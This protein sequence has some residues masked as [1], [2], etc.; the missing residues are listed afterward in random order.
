M[1]IN[2][3]LILGILLLTLP[4]SGFSGG[5]GSKPLSH[6]AGIMHDLN[7]YPDANGKKT[8]QQIMDDKSVRENER[9]LAHAMMRLEHKVNSADV[10]KLKAIMN[11]SEATQNEKDMAKII[12]NLNHA[13]SD[14]DKKMLKGMK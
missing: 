10:D 2:S 14:D 11:S 9:T 13:P 12:L 8:L 4:V 5:M 1:R 7:H 6:M 3:L